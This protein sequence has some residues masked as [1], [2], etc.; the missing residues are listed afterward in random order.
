[1]QLL[2]LSR[3]AA[4]LGLEL[5]QAVQL[6]VGPQ[7]GDFFG[8]LLD[9]R[10]LTHGLAGMRHHGHRHFF[11]GIHFVILISVIGVGAV[12]LLVDLSLRELVLVFVL[13]TL[14]R[15]AHLALFPAGVAA[16]GHVEIADKG[17]GIGHVVG[18]GELELLVHHGDELFEQLLVGLGAAF[19]G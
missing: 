18:D 5:G 14:V 8:Q 2:G 16:A 17:L 19:L 4:A 11:A 12:V 1:A 7:A 13:A 9:D 3:R 6:L 15:A 10:R